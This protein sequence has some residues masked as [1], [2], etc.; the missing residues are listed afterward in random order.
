[1]TNMITPELCQQQAE[2]AQARQAIYQL[3]AVALGYPLP[4][5]Q[6]ALE[7]GRLQMALD[8]AWQTLGGQPWPQLETAESMQELEMGYMSIFIHGRRGKPRVPLV[9]SA[10]ANL[11]EGLTPGA[12]L[13]NVQ[14]FY[15]HF[16]LTAAVNDEGLKDEPDH[17][18]AMLEFCALLCHFEIEALANNKDAAPYRRAQR[19]FLARYVAPLL[20]II[21]AGYAEA[22]HYG[23]EPNLAHLVE[24][25]P[26][27][28]LAQ[29]STL[30]AL[31]GATPQPG[32]DKTIPVNQPMWD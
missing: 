4:E 16:G 25:L 3:S 17:I 23:L 15:T 8:E 11:V 9:A 27:W 13:L 12:Y 24:V 30:E 21:R 19:D 5:T 7:E 31:V 2:Q 22:S 14:A 6:Q 18:V 10:Y 32:A 26:E 1:M 20:H 28:A 29:Q